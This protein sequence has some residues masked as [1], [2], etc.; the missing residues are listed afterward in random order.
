MKETKKNSETSSGKR[1]VYPG[2]RISTSADVLR[3]SF[4]GRPKS[5][6]IES[7]GPTHEQIAE[8]AYSLWKE[9]G[10]ESDKEED[11]WNQAEAE[12][13]DEDLEKI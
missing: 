1:S 8:R 10:R 4:D 11:F 5:P 9:N 3:P 2:K 12:L 6:D 7:V 13:R